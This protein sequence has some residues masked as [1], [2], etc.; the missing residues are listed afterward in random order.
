MDWVNFNMNPLINNLFAV[1]R[2]SAPLRW[3]PTLPARH[4]TRSTLIL[5][6]LTVF[7]ACSPSHEMNS[8]EQEIRLVREASNAAIAAHDTTAMAKTLS[9]DYNVVTSRNAVSVGR[10][11]M[12]QRF[13]ADAPDVIYIRTSDVIRVFPEWKM[14]SETGTWVGRWK[15][16]S[17][18]I[19][20]SGTYYAKWHKVDGKWVIRAEVFTPL[21][22]TGGQFCDRSPI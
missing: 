6:S 10:S 8:D 21:R 1:L 12:L 20:L 22:C 17:D 3:L 7:Y 2:A 16:G 15:D 19:E 4:N 13:A 11:A 5:G 9:V 18:S 14:A